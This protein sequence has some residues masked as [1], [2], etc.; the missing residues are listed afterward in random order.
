MRNV[1]FYKHLNEDDKVKFS[2]EETAKKV[3]ELNYGTQRFFCE[4][5]R[6]RE[7]SENMK[8]KEFERH[9]KQLR[10][11]LESGFY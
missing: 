10:D 8:Y 11:L 5:L 4:I 2:M 3:D 9:T 1:D 7:N 6:I